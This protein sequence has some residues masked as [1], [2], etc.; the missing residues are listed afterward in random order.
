LPTLTTEF[1][2]RHVW[3]TKADA[4]SAVG[5][6]IEERFNRLRRHSSIHMMTPVQY[7]NHLQQTATL[8]A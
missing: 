1:Y 6:W 2:H 5:R 7:E 4:A 8:A 3:A